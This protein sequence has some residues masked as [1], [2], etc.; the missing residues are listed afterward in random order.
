M[1]KYWLILTGFAAV[2]AAMVSCKKDPPADAVFSGTGGSAFLKIV[3][4]SPYFSRLSGASDS[5]NVYINNSKLSGGILSYGSIFPGV[6]GSPLNTG[7][8]VTVP[9]GNQTIRVT[10]NGK[11]TPDSTT[12]V[13]LQR[14][15]LAGTYYTLA[16]TDSVKLATRDSSLIFLRDS[17]PLPMAGPGFTYVRMIHAVEND[18]ANATVNV[19]SYRLN[20]AVL[21]KVRINQTTA[22]T[23]IPALAGGIIDTL[24]LKRSDTSKYVIAKIPTAMVEQHCYTLLYAGNDTTHLAGKGKTLSYFINK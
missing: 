4:A 12:L 14:N 9:A 13:S 21:T 8:Y 24:Y 6:A 2:T 15:L 16:L 7:T 22:F 5:L 17:F 1:K 19:Y 18:T 11:T 20:T 23:A 10:L 3:H